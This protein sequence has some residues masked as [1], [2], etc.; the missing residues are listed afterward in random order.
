MEV[1]IKNTTNKKR[2]AVVFGFNYTLP[3]NI[4]IEQSKE[5]NFFN[6]KTD[7]GVEITYDGDGSKEHLESM[8]NEMGLNPILI[9]NIEYTSSNNKISNVFY[10]LNID[11]NGKMQFDPIYPQI[12]VTPQQ[13][14]LFP[15]IIHNEYSG[16]IKGIDCN[17]S[18]LFV[19][20]PNEEIDLKINEKIIVSQTA[21][22]NR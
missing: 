14:S 16:K 19:L 6:I 2:K 3:V 15:I 13:E 18:L 12:Y 21:K 22:L 10:C 8:Y 7:D 11:A 20:E 9:T 1:K 5:C 4:A 17:T